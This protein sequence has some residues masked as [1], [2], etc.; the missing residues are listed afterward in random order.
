MKNQTLVKRYT[1]GLA[2]AFS[3]DSE[4]EAVSRELAD[5]SALLNANASLRHA[6]LR[7]F[8]NAAK[9][10]SLVRAVLE[11][12]KAQAKTARFLELLLHHGRLE[13]LSDVLAALP[14]AWRDRS[15][16]L[17]FEVSSV[18]PLSAAQ[19]KR[20]EAELA[21]I[22]NHPVHCDYALDPSLIGGLSVRRG[23]LIY[24]ASLKGRLEQ[25]KAQIRER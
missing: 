20:L 14:T 15:G 5:F 12:E 6:L 1:D 22:E 24:D 23:N 17:S 18:V 25:L 19:K 8:L 2:G 13:I 7:P 21:L 11:A 3:S 16:I 10:G 9:K 4:Y